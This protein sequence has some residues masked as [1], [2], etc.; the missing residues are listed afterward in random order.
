MWEID[1]LIAEIETAFRTRTSLYELR[2][3]ARAPD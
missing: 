2:I 1:Q 3:G